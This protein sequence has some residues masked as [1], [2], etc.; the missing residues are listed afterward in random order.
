[1]HFDFTAIEESHMSRALKASHTRF[2]IPLA[3]VAT[4]LFATTVHAA[5][6]YLPAGQPD[7]VALLA[8]P[9]EAD[10]FEQASDLAAVQAAFKNRAKADEELGKVQKEITFYSF[11]PVIGP[12]LDVEKLPRTTALFEKVAKDNKQAVDAG[13]EHWKRTRPYEIDLS[14]LHG[15]KEPSPSYPS[16]HS[17][18][19]TV[20]ALLLAELFPE[21]KDEILKY[22][23]EIGWR[24]V[25]TGKHFPTDIYAGRVL[26]QAIVRQLHANPEFEHDFAAVKAEIN[27]ESRTKTAQK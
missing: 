2:R 10:S 16:G 23:R 27:T 14:L 1:L 21:K 9:P 22:G 4:A 17:T 25:V 5:S 12:V 13:K 6:G 24:R 11:A 15:D 8:P 7:V 20:Y 19:G 26:G 18:R 3:I